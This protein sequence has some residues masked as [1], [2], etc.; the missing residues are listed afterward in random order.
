VNIILRENLVDT[1]PERNVYIKVTI[2]IANIRT[3]R[4][5]VSE[6]NHFLIHSSLFSTNLS[7]SLYIFLDKTT[8]I[9]KD[10][11]SKDRE[12]ATCSLIEL[13]LKLLNES[14]NCKLITAKVK[15]IKLITVV[16]RLTINP[17]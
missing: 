4:K 13:M 2:V 10:T 7:K 16:Y 3:N 14:G 6:R 9:G 1:S 12:N 8:N 5:I 17:R 11:I 15:N